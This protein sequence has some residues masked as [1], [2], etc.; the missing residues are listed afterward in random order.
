MINPPPPE[1][2]LF[3]D[4]DNRPH[5]AEPEPAIMPRKLVFCGVLA[6]LVI[7]GLVY[8]FAFSGDDVPIEPVIVQADA[9]PAKERPE[10]PGGIEIP[11]QDIN[12]YNKIAGDAGA[13]T[14]K[15]ERLLPPAEKPAPENVE[16][17]ASVEK[18]VAT[19]EPKEAE[20]PAAK[21]EEKPPEAA[22][23]EPAKTSESTSKQQV[24]KGSTRVQLA[25]FP[26]ASKA[27]AELARLQKKYSGALGDVKLL[28]IRADLGSKGVYYR[29][30]SPGISTKDA[31]RI[32]TDIKAQKGGCLVVK[33]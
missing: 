14:Q 27:K 9:E 16:P 11:Y 21:V 26:D 25:A 15:V 24:Q 22:K 28:V 30:Q 8:F 31:E 12:I 10:Q 1:S 19:E 4:P 17:E 23:P 29:I 32:C 5:H 20:K 13:G 18:P 33:P 2:S 7:A 3:P 6:L